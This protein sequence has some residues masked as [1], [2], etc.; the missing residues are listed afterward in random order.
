MNFYNLNY[1]ENQANLNNYLKYG[2]MAVAVLVMLGGLV[3]YMRHRLQTKYRDLAIMML[4]VLVFFGG[5]QYSD[6]KQ[7]S[8]QRDQTSQMAGFLASV[9]KDQDVP[10]KQVY[11]NATQL[12]DGIVLRINQRYYRVDLSADA[13]SYVLHRTHLVNRHVQ[14]HE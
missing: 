5:V 3:L 10:Q 8:S 4:L 14:L 9:A 6:Y 11:A 1:V 2:V 7:A 12:S 13:S